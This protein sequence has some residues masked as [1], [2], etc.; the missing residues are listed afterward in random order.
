MIKKFDEFSKISESSSTDLPSGNEIDAREDISSRAPGKRIQVS[1]EID[2]GYEVHPTISVYFP[3]LFMYIDLD[4]IDVRDYDKLSTSTAVKIGEIVQNL[5]E[6]LD[7]E[8]E[9]CIENMQKKLK[10]A[11]SEIHALTSVKSKR[12]G[13]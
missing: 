2:S 5:D 9:T 6:S 11:A 13:L 7:I 4:K 3:D 12:F 1:T 10:N 8:L